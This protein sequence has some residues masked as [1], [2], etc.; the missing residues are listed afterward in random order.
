MPA[1]ETSLFPCNS[2]KVRDYCVVIT[3]RQ[4][5]LYLQTA[6][7]ARLGLSQEGILPFPAQSK[8]ILR[9]G[10]FELELRAGELRKSGLRI[11]LQQQ[12]LQI[13]QILVERSGEVVTREELRQKLWPAGTYVDFERSLNK[14]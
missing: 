4:V 7:N 9:F 13:L 12:P 5:A 2:L 6:Q 11:K 10:A 14:A 3:R 1:L 8:N